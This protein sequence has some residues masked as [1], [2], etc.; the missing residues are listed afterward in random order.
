ML[1]CHKLDISSRAAVL[2][3]MSYVRCASPCMQQSA[4]TDMPASWEVV[5]HWAPHPVLSIISGLSNTTTRQHGITTTAVGRRSCRTHENC[6]HA[7]QIIIIFYIIFFF[8]LCTEKKS[9]DLTQSSSFA[10]VS[11]TYHLHSSSGLMH[12]PSRLTKCHFESSSLIT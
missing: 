10:V 9:V 5:C 1:I 8:A 4:V 3:S 2:Q 12:P 11:R 6:M 7:E